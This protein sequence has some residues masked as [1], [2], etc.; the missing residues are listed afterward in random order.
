MS[1]ALSRTPKYATLLGLDHT[2][3]LGLGSTSL[4]AFLVTT[5]IG[6]IELW[7]SLALFIYTAALV[8]GVHINPLVSI[9]TFVTRLST[10]PR[11]VLYILFQDLGGM[12]EGFLLRA[13]LPEVY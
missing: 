10:F 2:R 5:L 3:I 4:Y 9:A 6:A 11:V 12:I 7:V 13:G 1:A 8:S